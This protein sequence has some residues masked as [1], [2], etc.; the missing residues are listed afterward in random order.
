MQGDVQLHVLLHIALTVHRLVHGAQVQAQLLAYGVVCHIVQRPSGRH[1]L[2]ALS[3]TILVVS[4][5][6]IGGGTHLL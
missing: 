5:S 3:V 4:T 2:V 6:C 1:S